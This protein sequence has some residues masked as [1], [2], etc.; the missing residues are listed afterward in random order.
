[1]SVQD[2]EE[3]KGDEHKW[4]YAIKAAGGTDPFSV[5]AKIEKEIRE[6]GGPCRAPPFLCAPPFCFCI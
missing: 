3:V 2:N 5:P 4:E 6:V 1:M